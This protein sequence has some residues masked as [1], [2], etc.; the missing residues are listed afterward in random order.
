VRHNVETMRAAGADI[1]RI[2]AVGGG[3][4]GALW[5]QIVSDAT[6]LV[7]EVPATTIGASYGA[8]FLARAAADATSP[9]IQ[10]W[11]PTAARI[12]PDPAVAPA[13]DE[14]FDRYVRLYTATKELVH[15]L[16]ADQR[17]TDASAA[18]V[19]AGASDGGTPDPSPQEIP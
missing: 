2:V 6:G 15:E 13:Y 7:Q 9:R 11:N 3:T 16:A 4:Q 14:L 1:R 18:L 17:G 8:A 5:L 19:S 12:T 10:D